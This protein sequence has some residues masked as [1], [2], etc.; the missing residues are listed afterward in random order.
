[1]IRHIRAERSH[2]SRP[3]NNYQ[4]VRMTLHILLHSVM[5]ETIIALVLCWG[6]TTPP[7]FHTD[8]AKK[9]HRAPFGGI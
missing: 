1:M 8:N 9:Q 7:C 2:F 5:P 4:A 3:N 6:Y